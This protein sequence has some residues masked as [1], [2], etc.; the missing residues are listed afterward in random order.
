M[1]TKSQTIP[2]I[3]SIL[4]VGAFITYCLAGTNENR[5]TCP[6]AMIDHAITGK[7]CPVVGRIGNVKLAI[8]NHYILGPVAYKGVDIWNAE[9]YKNRPKHPALDTEIDNFAIKVRLNNFKPVENDKDFKDYDKLGEAGGWKQ[10]PENRWVFIGFKNLD[11]QY[12]IK[13]HVNNWLKDDAKYGPFVK[14]ESKWGL[15]H[16]ASIQ[17]ATTQNDKHEIYYDPIFG[18]TFI[19]CSHRLIAIPPNEPIMHCRFTLN[20]KE[21]QVEV[22]VGDIQFADDLARWNEIQETITKLFSSFIIN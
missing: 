7:T 15:E 3:A 4:L 9:S 20:L 21:Y 16:Y 14:V 5:S 10:P 17:N 1:L 12:N 8:P 22:N 6:V 13:T 18:K 11:N 2:I 19:N